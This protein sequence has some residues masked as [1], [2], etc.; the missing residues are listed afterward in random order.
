M[1]ENSFQTLCG[2]IH[3]WISIANPDR[4]TLVMLPGLTADHHLFDK[5][6]EAFEPQYNLFVW[7]APGH[8][9]SRPFALTFSLMDKAEWLHSILETEGIKNPILIGQ[10]IGGYVSQAFIQRYPGEASG[11]ISIDS[12][13][14]KR[15]YYPNWELRLLHHI[16]PLYRMYPW[17]MLVKQGSRG[18]AATTYG[19]QLM[20]RMMHEYDED[21]KY[22]SRLVG[23]GYGMLADAIE[24]NLPYNIDCPCILICGEKDKAGD[25]KSFNQRWAEGENL[26]IH[27]L[28]GAGHNS[29][30]DRPGE[31][32]KLVKHFIEHGQEQHPMRKL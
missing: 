6:V 22:Y 24:A 14:L 3:Y 7:D 18:T 30:T 20:A 26:P 17:K 8:A 29:N 27:W 4:P 9:A 10:S 25:T 16:E 11:F 21:H 28:A 12:A 23:H 31:I 32:N 2:G 15:K 1:I 13:P 5:Q 19:R